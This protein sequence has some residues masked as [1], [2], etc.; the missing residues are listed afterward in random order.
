M[1]V[2]D[3]IALGQGLE[4]TMHGVHDARPAHIASDHFPVRADLRRAA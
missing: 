2:L 4:A 1:G 3:R